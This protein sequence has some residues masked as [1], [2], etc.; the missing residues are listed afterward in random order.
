MLDLVIVIQ[1]GKEVSMLA[2]EFSTLIIIIL[3]TLIVG[4]IIGV[5]LSRPSVR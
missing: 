5:S 2:L 3:I 4:I 1:E